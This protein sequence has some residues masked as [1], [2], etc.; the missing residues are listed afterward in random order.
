MCVRARDMDIHICV[1]R[2]CA[3]ALYIIMT[4]GISIS[5]NLV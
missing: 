5:N 2:A 1:Y 4:K 3:R